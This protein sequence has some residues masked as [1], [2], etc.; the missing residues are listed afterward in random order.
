MGGGAHTTGLTAHHAGKGNGDVA[1]GHHL[2]P[3]IQGDL[4]TIKALESFPFS[5]LSQ[6]KVCGL[7]GAS[8]Q[9]IQHVCVKCM[10][11]LPLFQHH[12]VGEIHQHVHAVHPRPLKPLTQP[13][14]R[15]LRP[16]DAG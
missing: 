16:I 7:H 11:R 12:Q 8:T 15:R 4:T 10:Q 3:G 14:G 1:A 13:G 6:A 9:L 2:C 5:G